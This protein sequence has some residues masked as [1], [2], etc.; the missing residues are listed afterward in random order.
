M[1]TPVDLS[2]VSGLTVKQANSDFLQQ[3]DKTGLVKFIAEVVAVAVAAPDSAVEVKVT[4][5]VKRLGDWRREYKV[6]TVSVYFQRILVRQQQWLVNNDG[7]ETTIRPMLDVSHRGKT[8][9]GQYKQWFVDNTIDRDDLNN[10]IRPHLHCYYSG[11]CLHG[12]YTAWYYSGKLHLV[13]QY[14]HGDKHGKF[15]SYYDREN[16]NIYKQCWYQQGKKR[17][18]Y[19][20]Y[21]ADGLLRY[22]GNFIG[23]STTNFDMSLD[24]H[25]GRY[26]VSDGLQGYPRNRTID[27]SGAAGLCGLDY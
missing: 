13:T 11:G 21:L 18:H 17:C 19:M 20:E 23:D 22:F 5:A 15:T 9:H 14:Q 3:T 2:T 10:D 25:S 7:N 27:F 1:N 26:L 4:Y 8:L 16:A 24:P 6:K 12:D